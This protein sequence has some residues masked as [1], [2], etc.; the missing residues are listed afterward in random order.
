MENISAMDVALLGLLAE[1]P[2]HPWEITKQVE[3]REMRTWTDLARSTVY[4]Q[5]A[6]LEARGLVRTEDEVASSR[7]RRVHQLTPAGRA[8]LAGGVT[9]LLGEPQYPHW[10]IDIATYNLDAIPPAEAV[11]ALDKYAR[12][13]RE[14][15][16]GWSKLEAFLRDEEKCPPHRWALARRA[17][18]MIDGE[19][20]W[21]AEFRAE[22]EAAR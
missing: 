10:G 15:S 21:I 12:T 7:V 18:A 22:L 5:L 11:A 1:R 14:C 9:R 6:S 17:R 16:A 19:L 8:A 3:Y 20:R 4:K 13:L 2:M